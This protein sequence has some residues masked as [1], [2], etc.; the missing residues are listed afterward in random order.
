MLIKFNQPNTVTVCF[1]PH[2]EGLYEAV[3]ELDFCDHKHK[4]DFTIKRT[5][6]GRTTQVVLG[7][8][9]QSARE[10]GHLQIEYK[11]NTCSQPA[12]DQVDNGIP[13]EELE[14][15]SDNDDTGI[16]VSN[17]DGLDFGIVERLR[18]NGPF[19]TSSSFLSI[20]NKDNFPAVVFI[21]GRIKTSDG[22]DREWVIDRPYFCLIHHFPS[23][24]FKGDP[25]SIL[26]GTETTV[27]VIFCPRFEGL[28]KATIELVFYLTQGSVWFVVSR[29]LQGIAG[30]L[31]DHKHFESLGQEDLRIIKSRALSPQKTILL[32]SP[33]RRRRSRYFPDH[34]VPP[35]VQETVDES[36]VAHP[37]DENAPR[38]IS[39]LMPDSLNMNTYANYFNAL[40]AI[41]DGHRQYVSYLFSSLGSNV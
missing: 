26:P 34:E 25:R 3:L 2:R 7:Q 24:A 6:S 14:E 21:R 22:S 27:H 29:K 1:T 32:L 38:L 13:A 36:T 8:A 15:L 40:L 12:N 20:K 37:Y 30:S 17:A 39:A 9:K 19:A 28:F 10:Q 11:P 33:D 35:I 18:R 31:E 4:A 16:S 5:L 23:F 41:E